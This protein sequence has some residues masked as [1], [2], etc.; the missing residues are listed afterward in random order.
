MGII[1]VCL[2]VDYFGWGYF[3]GDVVVF[4]YDNIE[5]DVVVGG[6]LSIVGYLD[7]L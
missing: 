3:G 2:G 1:W 4:L 5:I 6:C 7:V